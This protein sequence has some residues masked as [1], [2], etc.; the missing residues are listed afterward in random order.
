[1]SKKQEEKETN[2]FDYYYKPDDRVEISGFLFNRLMN[3]LARET[4]AERK[5]FFEEQLTEDGQFDLE[6]TMTKPVRKTFFTS[7]G[8]VLNE[9]Y[10]ELLAFH[11]EHI[12]SGKATSKGGAKMEKV[13]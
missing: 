11:A 2:P 4:D 10:Y 9:M 12:E 7:K 1:M 5:D 6:K 8:M 3:F 13:D